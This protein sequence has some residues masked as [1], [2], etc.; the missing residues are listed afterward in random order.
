MKRIQLFAALVLLCPAYAPGASKETIELQRDV[1]QLQDQVRELQRAFDE[2]F[3]ALQVLVQQT[4][5]VS[6]RSGAAL[7]AQSRNEAGA[8]DRM[9]APIAGLSSKVDA[10]GGDV[11]AMREA[12]NDL[13]SRLNKVQQQLTD[14]GNV[15]KAT[16]MPVAPPPT[17]GGAPMSAA[18][19]SSA[20][21]YPAQG[22][23]QGGAGAPP[24]PAT[25]LYENAFR[26]MQS[27]KADLA[28]GEFQDYLRFYNDTDAAPA[29]QFYIGQ[30]HASQ[31]QF[32][33]AIQ[34]F[35][36]VLEAY[37]NN[38]KTP[39]AHFQK[40]K[41]LF[42]LGQRNAAAKEFESVLNDFPRSSVAPQARAQL[43]ALGINPPAAA[44]RRK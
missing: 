27:G 41:T 4:L 36:R 34:D 30:I 28:S 33:L 15:V 23:P 25:A 3:S 7:D 1:A 11:S 21:S 17:G 38:S 18:P 35:D 37:P 42:Q 6:N 13:T 14:L 44:A 9:I 24:V 32:D 29:A 2:R 31:S 16:Q 8:A 20:A 19:D 43:K 12:V 40:G 5:D 26:D 22:A 10:M 39:D